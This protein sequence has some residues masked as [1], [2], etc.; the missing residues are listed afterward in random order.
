MV[1]SGASFTFPVTFNLSDA[2]ILAYQNAGNGE[3][4]SGAESIAPNLVTT[5]TASGFAGDT[6]IRLSGTVV[7]SAGYL[8]INQTTVDFGG[9]VTG[10]AQSTRNKGNSALT[11]TGFAWQYYYATGV[12][13]NNVCV[14]ATFIVEYDVPFLSFVVV[15][16]IVN[17]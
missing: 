7:A 5:A 6:I 11:F 14:S 8:V 2:N 9:V 4:L 1:G 10:G 17:V 12:P 3:A 16:Y 13:F 15:S